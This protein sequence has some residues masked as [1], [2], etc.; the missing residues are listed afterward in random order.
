MHGSAWV[1]LLRR[2]PAD[3][4]DKIVLNTGAGTEVNLQ[5]VLRTEGHYLVIRGRLAASTDA[6]RV[7]FVPY[8]QIRLLGFREAISE[9]KVAEWFGGPAPAPA[10]SEAGHTMLSTQLPAVPLAPGSNGSA[11]APQPASSPALSPAKAA[12]LE[13]LRRARLGPEGP[14]DSHR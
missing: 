10:S 7:F 2:I 1:E 8:E 5:T 9:A 6:G 12:L 4:H 3:H 14:R 11:S 13:R